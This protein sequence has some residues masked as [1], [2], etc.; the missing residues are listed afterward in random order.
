MQT[1]VPSLK[2]GRAAVEFV[3]FDQ[4]VE[5]DL[6]LGGVLVGVD[7][8]VTELA[9]LA[10]ERNVNI[11]AERIVDARRLVERR[12]GLANKLRFPLRKRRII[13]NKIISDFS[14]LRSVK[15]SINVGGLPI[16]GSRNCQFVPD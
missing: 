9:A 6:N 3:L 16:A 4:R 5:I 12:D 2:R 11:K 15:I 7:F 8:E 13:R 1:A 10:A 14:S